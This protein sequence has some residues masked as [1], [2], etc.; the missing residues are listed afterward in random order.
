MCLNS[1]NQCEW[2]LSVIAACSRCASARAASS[3]AG[4]IPAIAARSLF[5]CAR[6][7]SA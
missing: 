2:L 1:L 3:L 5:I 6:Y 4:A 7:A